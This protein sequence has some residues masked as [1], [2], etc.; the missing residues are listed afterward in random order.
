MPSITRHKWGGGGINFRGDEL[1]V[2]RAKKP[3]AVAMGSKAH[4]KKEIWAAAFAKEGTQANISVCNR[5]GT[6]YLD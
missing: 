6:V 3:S 4:A 5:S 1:W 2:S